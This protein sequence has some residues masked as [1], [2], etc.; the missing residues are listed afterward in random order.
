MKLRY[1]ALHFPHQGATQEMT[2][3]HYGG[4]GSMFPSS[5]RGDGWI[6]LQNG[7]RESWCADVTRSWRRFQSPTAFIFWTK[8]VLADLVGQQDLKR[9]LSLRDGHQSWRSLRRTQHRSRRRVRNLGRSGLARSSMQCC[10]RTLRENFQHRA[11]HRARCGG[12][13]LAITQYSRWFQHVC[14]FL[15]VKPLSAMKVSAWICTC[16]TD[17]DLESGLSKSIDVRVPKTVNYA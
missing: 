14:K 3:E 16:A 10:C 9:I 8:Q 2:C 1:T 15:G 5:D 4:T 11:S 6:L 13:G 7:A 17:S 12:R